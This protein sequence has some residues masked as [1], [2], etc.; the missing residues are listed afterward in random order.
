MTADL[1]VADALLEVW[2][3]LVRRW[4]SAADSGSWSVAGGW[5][6]DAC[7]TTMDLGLALAGGA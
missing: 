4:W 7:A 1:G 3:W 6:G 2:R 5:R